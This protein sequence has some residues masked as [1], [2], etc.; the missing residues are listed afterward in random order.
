VKA[1]V[2]NIVNDVLRRRIR[3]RRL[4]IS[5]KATCEEGFEIPDSGR[6]QSLSESCHDLA[7]VDRVVA[8]LD[9]LAA[10]VIYLHDALGYD[11]LEVALILGVS[12]SAA[13]SR[14]VRTRKRIART[15][16]T[17]PKRSGVHRRRLGHRI[18]QGKSGGTCFMR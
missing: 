6:A 16:E 2:R 3:T 12:I 13:Q 1:I 7:S 18:D 5:T 17:E 4:F 14:L 8:D 10:G 9:S 15:L 11:L